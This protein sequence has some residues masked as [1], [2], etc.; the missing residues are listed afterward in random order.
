M[1]A[2]ERSVDE[3]VLPTKILNISKRPAGKD[4]RLTILVE[5]DIGEFSI[6]ELADMF[7]KS[8][9]QVR[10]SLKV[11]GKEALEFKQKR[12]GGSWEGL[13]DTAR[14]YNLKNIK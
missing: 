7:G 12:V 4:N 5:T 2:S 10:H 14:D 3:K 11:W 8:R 1:S 6:P 13:Q 9:H